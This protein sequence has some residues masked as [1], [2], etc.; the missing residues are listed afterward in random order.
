MMSWMPMKPRSLQTKWIDCHE[1][2]GPKQDNEH[3]DEKPHDGK[4]N[5]PPL[6]HIKDQMA[7]RKK[8]KHEK[9]SP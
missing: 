3:K 6:L 7:L 5:E 8:K 4:T 2:T 9:Q 1:H